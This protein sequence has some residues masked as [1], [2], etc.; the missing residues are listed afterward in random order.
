[1]GRPVRVELHR[2][3]LPLVTPLVSAHGVETARE[4]VL[5]HVTLDDGG[6]GWGECSAL[7]HPT[8]TAEYTGGAWAALRDELVPRFF[9]GRPWGIVG[10]PMASAAL[11][12]AEADAD[13]R[14][15]GRSLADQLALMHPGGRRDTVASCAVVGRGRTIEAVLSEVAE[16]VAEGHRHVKL[17]IGP[18]AVDLDALAATRDS[19]PDLDLA[20]DANGSLSSVDD[21]SLDR[22]DALGLT[23]LEQ[24]LP[25]DD[26][27]GASV[28]ADRLSTPVALDESITS[29]A[30]ARTAV[31]FGAADVLN[32]KPAR[33]GGPVEAARIVATARDL[34]VP[35]FVGGMLETGIGRATALAVASLPGCTLATDLGP[36]G[37]YFS[38]DVTVP[39]PLADNGTLTVPGGP[40][41]GV[42]PDRARL[43]AAQVD[44]LVLEVRR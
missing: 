22:I 18:H 41:I 44:H 14:R 8:Y 33:V 13:L 7:V 43:A 26:L 23:Y 9:A 24:P 19:W 2:V 6:Q 28:L 10:H 36:S 11:L 32:V 40:G 38:T 17:K 20:A 39:I 1:M 37:R 42:E 15:V 31:R 16:R 29:D 5:V 30:A 3:S 34:G 27:A 4:L 21:R 25:A 35:A 12:T